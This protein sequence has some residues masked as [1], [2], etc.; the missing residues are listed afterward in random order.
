MQGAT[1]VV[2]FFYPG[3]REEGGRGCDELTT[4][5]SGAG[6]GAVYRRGKTESAAVRS[7]GVRRKGECLGAGEEGRR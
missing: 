6:G 4:L 2:F 7:E 3:V 1:A 5:R